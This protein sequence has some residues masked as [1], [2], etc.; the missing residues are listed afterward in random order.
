MGTRVVH[1]KKSDYDIYIGRGRCP[2]TGTVNQFGN[3][4]KIGRDGSRGVV[5]IKFKAWMVTG[6]NFGCQEATDAKRSWILAHLEELRDKVIAC[7]CAPEDCHGNV[8]A[9]LL[10]KC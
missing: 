4:F 5:C 9:E 6:N 2:K 10:D 7:W 1:C 8:Y 3:P